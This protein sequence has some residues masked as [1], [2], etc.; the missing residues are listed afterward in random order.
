MSMVRDIGI[1]SD[2]SYLWLKLKQKFMDSF[3]DLMGY[4]NHS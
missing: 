3:T 1:E 4:K 2:Q